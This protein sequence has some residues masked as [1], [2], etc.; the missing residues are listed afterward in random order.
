MVTWIVRTRSTP[1]LFFSL[2]PSIQIQLVLYLSKPLSTCIHSV[3]ITNYMKNSR[4]QM[5]TQMDSI[6]GLFQSPTNLDNN[7]INLT[8]VQIDGFLKCP[9]IINYLI[10]K[11]IIRFN[12][13]TYEP[14][15][16]HIYILLLRHYPAR[17]SCAAHQS[18]LGSISQNALYFSASNG[19]RSK[20]PYRALSFLQSPRLSIS[21]WPILA[22]RFF[23]RIVGRAPVLASLLT[24]I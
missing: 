8:R 5:S 3:V 13:F 22:P 23:G 15:I 18:V 14:Y 2:L 9:I 12:L 11:L 21:R 6:C 16:Y 4:T 1:W 17:I 19:C 20:Q 7:R 24:S 10:I